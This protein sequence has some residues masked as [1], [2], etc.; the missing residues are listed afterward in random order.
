MS[1]QCNS[2]SSTNLLIVNTSEKL[3]WSNNRTVTIRTNS[4]HSATECIACLHVKLPTHFCSVQLVCRTPCWNVYDLNSCL[5]CLIQ[6]KHV[7]FRKQNDLSP[8]QLGSRMWITIIWQA[9]SSNTEVVSKM[10][11]C[12]R[13]GID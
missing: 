6:T 7:K 11:F 9:V 2:R 4:S 8:T 1:I 10:C 5:K 12:S 3:D 13:T